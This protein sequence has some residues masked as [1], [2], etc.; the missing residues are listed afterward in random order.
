MGQPKVDQAVSPFA[1]AVYCILRF[2]IF[3]HYFEFM[4]GQ[5]GLTQLP[6]DFPQLLLMLRLGLNNSNPVFNQLAFF[7]LEGDSVVIHK[8]IYLLDFRF[9][10]FH[11]LDVWPYP[12]DVCQLAHPKLLYRIS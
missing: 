3:V 9:F 1:G 8:D 4:Q 10:S 7:H 5:H 11:T 12:Q 2:D 6:L